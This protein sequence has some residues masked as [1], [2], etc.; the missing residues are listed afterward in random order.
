MIPRRILPL[1]ALA[2]L[3][4][5]VVHPARAGTGPA[6]KC[7]SHFMYWHP[8]GPASSES[9][10]YIDQIPVSA[11]GTPPDAPGDTINLQWTYGLGQ[12]GAGN[13]PRIYDEQTLPR[14]QLIPIIVGRIPDPRY[15][16]GPCLPYKP[17]ELVC[18]DD[19][20]MCQPR[21]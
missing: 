3:A 16:E 21:E 12:N 19:Q 8:D 2:L 14:K 10:P 13:I 15:S 7:G 20:P 18:S 11:S 4:P 9:R 17:N 1:A 6:L 5:L